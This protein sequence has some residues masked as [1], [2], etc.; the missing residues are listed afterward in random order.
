M[1]CTA[2]TQK[3]ELIVEDIEKEPVSASPSEGSLHD[4]NQMESDKSEQNV[5]DTVDREVPNDGCHDVGGEM[6]TEPETTESAT[7]RSKF[8]C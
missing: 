6:L 1:L 8:K 5:E 2:V 7:V 4:K 3:E